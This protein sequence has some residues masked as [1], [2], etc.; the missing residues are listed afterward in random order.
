M[1][2]TSHRAIL[3]TC[4]WFDVKKGGSDWMPPLLKK[5][6]INY[7]NYFQNT[8]A[9]FKGCKTPKRVPDY[10]SKDRYGQ[11]SSTYWYGKDKKG[12]YIIRR[13]NHWVHRQPLGK[14]KGA[15][16]CKRI[17]SC[18]WHLRTH[19]VEYYKNLGITTKYSNYLTGKCYLKDFKKLA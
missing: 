5:I 8:A 9:I 3:I 2:Y 19:M 15:T 4:S 12:E 13:S 18:V 11:K 17:S 6:M 7:N 16:Q 10:V 1:L 14:E